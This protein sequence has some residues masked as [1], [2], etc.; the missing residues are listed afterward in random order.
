MNMSEYYETLK[1]QVAERFPREAMVWSCF[2]DQWRVKCPASKAHSLLSHFKSAQGYDQLT[3]ITVI[4]RLEYPRAEDRF[5][6]VYIL[7][8]TESGRRVT[9]LVPLN[10]PNLTVPTVYNLW[11]AADWLE[12][13]AYDMFGIVFEGHPNFKRLLLPDQ[14]T[15]FPLRKDYPVKGRGERHNFSVLTRADS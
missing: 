7:L 4:D 6:L 13:E 1:Q 8:N 12:R 15:A 10:E 5:E 14:F 3:D 9:V 2:R 11:T